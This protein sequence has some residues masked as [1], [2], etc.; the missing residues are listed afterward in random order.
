MK[1]PLKLMHLKNKHIGETGII[2]GGGPSIKHLLDQK[3]PFDKLDMYTTIGTNMS[4]TIHDSDYLLFMDRYFWH[5]FYKDINKLKLT[6]VL[7]QLEREYNNKL[8]RPLPFDIVRIQS[9][10][11]FYPLIN[12]KN[13]CNNTGSAALS[14]SNYLG[15][16]K[17]YLFGIDMCV[18]KDE[19]KNFH[20]EYIKNGKRQPNN[21]NNISN[22][23]ANIGK[24]IGDLTENQNVEI[25]SCSKISKLNKFITYIDPFTLI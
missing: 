24:I 8:K 18:D 14:F 10:G 17:I 11:I 19:N 6:I 7:T 5:T 23:Y 9:K 2:I 15:L 22:H 25:Y 16:S 3:F 20:T 21:N 13:K 12:G 4:F 1:Q